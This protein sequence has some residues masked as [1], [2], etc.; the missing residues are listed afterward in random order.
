MGI[1]FMYALGIYIALLIMKIIPRTFATT[2]I[3]VI[4]IVL[5]IICTFVRF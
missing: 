3:L 5:A 4:M 2:S 1:I